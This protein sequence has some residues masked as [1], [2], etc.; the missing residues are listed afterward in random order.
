MIVVEVCFVS[1]SR[2]QNSSCKF[3]TSRGS[4]SGMVGS[5]SCTGFTSNVGNDTSTP[6]K[7]IN[8]LKIR[9]YIM[10]IKSFEQM[11]DQFL[12]C[13]VHFRQ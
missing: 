6:G 3:G 4:T 10:Q 7:E 9:N 13:I 2:R 5:R 1:I 11:D 8:M 12:E